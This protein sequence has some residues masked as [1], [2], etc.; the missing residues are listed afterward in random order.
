MPTDEHYFIG[1]TEETPRS[2]ELPI[3]FRIM[4]QGSSSAIVFLNQDVTR[5]TST[6]KISPVAALRDDRF[7]FVPKPLPL[8]RGT[9][10]LQLRAIYGSESCD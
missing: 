6:P 2:P 8:C 3:A 10:I 9:A 1:Q 5:P 7:V 4:V